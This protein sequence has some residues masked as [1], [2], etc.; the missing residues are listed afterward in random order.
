MRSWLRHGLRVDVNFLPLFSL[1]RRKKPQR[2]FNL[3]NLRKYGRY[4]ERSR[5]RKSLS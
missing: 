1:A 2:I 4:A 3:H 5:E